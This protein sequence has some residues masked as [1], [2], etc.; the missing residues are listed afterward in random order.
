M[1]NPPLSFNLSS[2]CLGLPLFFEWMIDGDPKNDPTLGTPTM[3]PSGLGY[4]DKVSSTETRRERATS[5]NHFR[6]STLL[7]F[8]IF[9]WLTSIFVLIFT[10]KAYYDDEDELEFYRSV[11]H[12]GLQTLQ[13][14]QEA[15]HK[16]NHFD[17][18]KKNKKKPDSSK[19]SKKEIK[20]LAEAVV[21][22][23]KSIASITPSGSS[24]AD[25]IKG[26]NARSVAQLS[27]EF[28]SVEW[29]SYLSALTVRPPNSIILRSPHFVKSLDSLISRTKTD[30]LEAYFSWTAIRTFGLNLGPNVP[31]RAAIDRLDRR[32]KGVEDGVKENRE[33]VCLASLQDAL[34][35]MSGRYFAEKDFPAESKRQ[36]E[37]IIK[38][39]IQAF[40]QKLP[41]LDWLDEKTRVTAEKKVSQGCEESGVAST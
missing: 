40:K 12:Q 36:G 14:E 31:L 33:T 37:V 32:S 41:D 18:S 38:D 34:G 22:L 27:Y 8:C 20:R 1:A 5:R 9:D 3:D 6:F 23:E 19:K 28:P 15:A 16:S 17:A 39:I 7:L 25:P 10:F 13:D 4:P 11:V 30:V 35:F 24:L 21:E 29:T 26:Y 2:L